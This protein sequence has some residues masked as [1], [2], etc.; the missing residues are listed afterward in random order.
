MKIF[1]KQFT[2]LLFEARYSNTS[3]WENLL[4]QHKVCEK[5]VGDNENTIVD[6]DKQLKEVQQLLHKEKQWSIGFVHS[7][8][9]QTSADPTS[10]CPSSTGFDILKIYKTIC[11]FK[12]DM[13]W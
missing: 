4:N 1:H 8:P 6:L 12:G 11:L 3:E 5:K 7:G 13:K 2:L 10:S 9:N